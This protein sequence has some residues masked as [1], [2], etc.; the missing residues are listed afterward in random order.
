MISA[1]YAADAS[2]HAAPFYATPEFWVAAAFVLVVGLAFRPVMRAV[3][4]G[5]DTRANQIKSKLDEA[6]R[7]REDSQAL[8]AE[9]QRKQ[10]DAL[11]EAE[12]IMTHAREEAARLKA[13][14]EK[15]LEQSI[16]RREKQ[17]VDRI[18]Q[19][20]AQAIAE[21]RNLAVDL[22]IAAA[23][24]LVAQQLTAPKADAL[25]DGA[26]RDLPGKLH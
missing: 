9:Y 21:V 13:D 7:L 4:A 22:A 20:E 10:R 11:A 1:A 26:I 12:S 25:I 8:L 14:A 6:R 17:A 15:A 3:T 19:A 2:G 24:K 23:G 16:A 18:A 5:L